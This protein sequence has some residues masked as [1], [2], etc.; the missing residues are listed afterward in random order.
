M[1]QLIKSPEKHIN[2]KVVV[3][4]FLLLI[5]ALL[6]FG[7]N[8]LGVIRFMV[9][10]DERDPLGERLR[11]LNQL[12]FRMQ[13]ADGA[14]RLYSLT[15]DDRHRQRYQTLNDSVLTT[16]EQLTIVFPDSASRSDVDTIRSLFMQKK[17]QTNQLVEVSIIDRHRRRYGEILSILPDSI[18]YQISQI[19][20]SSIR[21][22]SASAPVDRPQPAG[23]FGRIAGFL[24]GREQAL[25]P[26]QPTPG[27]EQRVDSSLIIR[28]RK[29]PALQQV[30]EQLTRLDEQDRRFA[31]LLRH[32]EEE[33]VQLGNQLMDK[34]REVIQGLEND[35]L[36]QS[37][38]RSLQMSNM[39]EELL[40]RLMFLG[41]SALIV[42]LAFI[43]WIGR[44][45][46]RSR[47]LKE[48]L[49]LQKQKVEKLARVKEQFL[50][51]MS[52]E[53]RMPLTSIIGFSEL[54][55]QKEE[56]ASVIRNSALHLL[57][58]INDVL[59]F[60]RMEA[61]KLL[62][63]EEC[64]H[65]NA[66]MEEVYNA[67][68]AK[69]REKQLSFNW[70]LHA[71]VMPFK[72]DKTRLRQILFNLTGNAIKFTDSGSVGL[73]VKTHENQ[74][75]FSVEDTG[76]GISDGQQAFVF[77]EFRQLAGPSAEGRGGAGLGLAIS[78]RL[79]EAMGGKIGLESE[80][81]KGSRFWFEIPYRTCEISVISDT[82]TERSLEGVNILVVDDDPLVCRL[83]EGFLKNE[84]HRLV[85]TVS[86]GKAL[87]ELKAGHFHLVI[88][89]NRMPEM[90]GS[91][92]IK[93]I[94]EE[95]KLEVPVLVLSAEMGSATTEA[96]QR[97]PMVFLMS[98]PF[99][100]EDLMNKVS[101]LMA[102]RDM[103]IAGPA[104]SPGDA[105][106]DLGGIRAFTGDDKA[107][108]QSVV[109]TF[110]NETD[111]NLELL[112]LLV[113]G[114]ME[115]SIPDQ[116][117][118][119]LTGFRQFNIAAGVQMLKGLEVLSMRSGNTREL[120]TGLKRLKKLWGK[121]RKE[122]SDIIN[123]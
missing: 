106:F 2:T 61:G 29:D 20:Y 102:G 67:F 82:Q 87:D 37:A 72:G 48:Q 89:D 75:V 114:Q 119:M 17:D 45:L 122:L 91:A 84:T 11:V 28:R 93:A 53:I 70:W 78:K 38:G 54:I 121:V 21:S 98:K 6:S 105:L 43:L 65:P 120:K 107:F 74:L 94:R 18:N 104:S 63:N 55:P 57:A 31:A 26:E 73:R 52:H 81:N 59:D 116:A 71:G 88:S 10:Q 15:G 19:T 60:S 51:N 50:A 69:A 4:F 12:V 108:F 64:I 79:V 3:V 9:T 103:A 30:K 32:Q 35:A 80:E 33:L 24:T 77:E 44:D 97:W 118:K 100:R 113:A 13:E 14:A 27:I 117:H 115:G 49:I 39:R 96:L 66:F 56:A 110:V 46:R 85:T 22:D 101:G 99:S 8:Y 25:P 36:L 86:P 1:N 47:L 95:L 7:V 23:F 90:D 123:Q 34:I 92:F 112:E 41:V 109:S 16:L 62:F 68:T 5:L 42:V 111:A 83:M 58:L 40:Q 76:C